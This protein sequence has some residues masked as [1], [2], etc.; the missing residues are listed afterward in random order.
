MSLMGSPFFRTF[1]GVMVFCTVSTF[2]RILLSVALFSIVPQTLT[3]VTPLHVK[4]VLYVEDFGTKVNFV[5]HLFVDS[6]P[7]E[8]LD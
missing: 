5:A 3:P 1:I 7:T 8:C 2:D 4:A 6:Q